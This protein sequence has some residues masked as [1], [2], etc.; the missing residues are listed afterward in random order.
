MLFRSRGRI[1][2]YHGPQI[3]AYDGTILA[4]A[5]I[6]GDWREELIT[7]V[8]GELRV[9]TTTIPAVDRR[10][11]LMK[12]DIYRMYVAMVSM[13]YL[14]PPQLSYYLNVGTP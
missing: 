11:T 4:V 6:L 3:G 9:Y 10:I 14:Y 8:P 5:D 7:T 13:G 2:R 1:Q 12:D